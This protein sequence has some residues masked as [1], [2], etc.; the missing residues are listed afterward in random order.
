MKTIQGISIQNLSF[1]YNNGQ[2]ILKDIDIEV[3]TGEFICLLGQSG[4]GKSTFLRL[5][6]G[7]ETPTAG[8]ILLNS[9]PIKGASLDRGVVFQDYSL[10]PLVKLLLHSS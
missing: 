10:F 6:M 3:H 7:L 9:Q 1:S 8:E 2:L 5:L 4:C